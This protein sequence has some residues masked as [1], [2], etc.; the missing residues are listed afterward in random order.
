MIRVLM[1]VLIARRRMMATL[2]MNALRSTLTIDN[3]LTLWSRQINPFIRIW[4]QNQMEMHA[5]RNK[6]HHSLKSRFLCRYPEGVWL[7]PILTVSQI[8]TA[9]VFLRMPLKQIKL[10]LAQ[11]RRAWVCSAVDAAKPSQRRLKAVK[12]FQNSKILSKRLRK[13]KLIYRSSIL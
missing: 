13:H 2:E 10:I 5:K 9:W 12:A 4:D 8:N 11:M 3:T 1:S 7:I 6:F